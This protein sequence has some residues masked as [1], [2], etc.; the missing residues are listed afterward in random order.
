MTA[1]TPWRAEW[2]CPHCPAVA[3]VTAAH[4]DL[5]GLELSGD[6]STFFSYP[7]ALAP[8]T[9]GQALALMAETVKQHEKA[10]HAWLT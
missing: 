2:H 6:G 4:K 3:R 1:T 8:L 9:F 10:Y 5:A 7:D